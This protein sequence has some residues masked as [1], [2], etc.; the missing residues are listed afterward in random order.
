MKTEESGTSGKRTRL[1]KMNNHDDN[2]KFSHCLQ[3]KKINKFKMEISGKTACTSMR[4]PGCT[5][6][7]SDSSIKFKDNG[8][9]KKI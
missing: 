2:D 6:Y 4:N 3:T 9:K 1:Q 8:L 7:K 5:S